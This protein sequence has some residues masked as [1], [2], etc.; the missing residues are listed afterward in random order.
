MPDGQQRARVSD[1]EIRRIA[2]R[3]I[4]D[5][6]SARCFADDDSIVHRKHELSPEDE[7]RVEL[8]LVEMGQVDIDVTSLAYRAH[9]DE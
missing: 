2:Q 5:G 9:G 4:D 6:G 8:A 1:A 3:I 7:D